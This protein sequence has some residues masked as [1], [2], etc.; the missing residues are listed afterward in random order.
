MTIGYFDRNEPSRRI[1]EKL[2]FQKLGVAHNAATRCLD[3]TNSIV[4]N[5]SWRAPMYYPTLMFRGVEAVPRI[6]GGNVAEARPRSRVFNSAQ[7]RR[8][9]HWR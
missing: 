1:V 7:P 9:E 4:M 6:P 2:G 5:T 3:G 8:G